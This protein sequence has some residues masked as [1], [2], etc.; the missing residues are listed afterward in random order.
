MPA[1]PLPPSDTDLIAAS[2]TGDAAAYATL[3]Q[4]HVAAYGLAWQLVRG[5]A[6]VTLTLPGPVVWADLYWAWRADSRGRR[7][8]CAAQAGPIGRSPATPPGP[9]S[10]WGIQGL[11]GI[12]VYQA[13]PT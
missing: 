8:A 13:S 12:P 5:P 2:R 9:L 6:S 1:E 4:R 3:Y 11:P 7:S 10:T